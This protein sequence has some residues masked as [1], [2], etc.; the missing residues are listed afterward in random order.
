MLAKWTSISNDLQIV[1]GA[2][3]GKC[4]GVECVALPQTF[5]RTPLFFMAP[6]SCTAPPP[7]IFAL[8]PFPIFSP[9]FTF[10]SMVNLYIHFTFSPSVTFSEPHSEKILNQQTVLCKPMSE[11]IVQILGIC[12]V[13]LCLNWHP[14]LSPS[15]LI[16]ICYSLWLS[17][18]F[19]SK[20][21][22]KMR[23]FW[24]E[25]LAL[26]LYSVFFGSCI[27][28]GCRPIH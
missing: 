25:N 20:A 26:A 8:L 7:C 23:Q 10:F 11:R 22:G 19:A 6:G 15:L 13:W 14:S 12:S 28:Q 21:A 16:W 18:N 9:S 24:I 2:R 5:D 3:W 1:V 17:L 4:V 27:H